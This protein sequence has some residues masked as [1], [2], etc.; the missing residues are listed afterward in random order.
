VKLDNLHQEHDAE[1]PYA[2]TLVLDSGGM[3]VRYGGETV[4][5]VS[6]EGLDPFE[7]AFHAMP[8]DWERHEEYDYNLSIFN[9]MTV[10]QHCENGIYAMLEELGKLRGW[11]RQ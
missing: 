6:F 10:E 7:I 9:Q 1:A 5:H 4:A 8:T 2:D 11:E 3:D